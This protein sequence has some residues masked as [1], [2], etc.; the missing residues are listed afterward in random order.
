MFSKEGAM[1]TSLLFNRP[2]E[3]IVAGDMDETH[4]GPCIQTLNLTNGDMII[5]ADC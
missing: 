2:G 5:Y 4:P 3:V 1:T